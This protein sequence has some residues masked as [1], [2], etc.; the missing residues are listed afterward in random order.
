MTWA[1][2]NHNWVMEMIFFSNMVAKKAALDSH[3]N[4]ETSL[5]WLQYPW[6]E[7]QTQSIL[8]RTF[9]II[10]IISVGEEHIPQHA[11][12]SQRATLWSRALSLPPPWCGLKDQTRAFAHW[13]VLLTSVLGVG[14][15]SQPL[16]CP[17]AELIFYIYLCLV[18]F[19]HKR[20]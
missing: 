16:Q 20:K 18:S 2:D 10:S 15:T 4:V 7:S 19:Y 3:N 14:K 8:G 1:L 17:L 12:L 6:L 5:R 11:C 9:L 13:V